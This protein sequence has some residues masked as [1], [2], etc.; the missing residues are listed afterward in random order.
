M[1]EL[2]DLVS[3]MRNAQSAYFRAR[4][5]GDHVQAGISMSES[6]RLESQVDKFIMQ[7][8]AEKVQPKLF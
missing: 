3:Q 4:K 7:Y 8:K 6:K 5:N 2:I 1:N